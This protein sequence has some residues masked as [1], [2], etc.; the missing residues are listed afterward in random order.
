MLNLLMVEDNQK[1]R[2]A[3]K[4]GLEKTGA[5]RV[6]YDCDSGEKA[7]AFCLETSTQALE[8]SSWPA[9][10]DREDCRSLPDV[11]LMDVQLTGK[12]NGIQ[13]AVA[14]R[15]EYPR[16]P[17]VFYSIQDQATLL[18]PSYEVTDFIDNSFQY[19]GD[20]FSG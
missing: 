20:G 12:M 18:F 17:V 11:I 19:G 3:L 5:V 14:V 10:Q 6:V 15:R 7:L 9:V 13:A 1:L 4:V 2:L 8:L 16:L